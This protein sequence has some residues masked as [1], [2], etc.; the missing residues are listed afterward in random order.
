MGQHTSPCHITE[1]A[2]EKPLH[3]ITWDLII[4]LAEHR[5]LRV[6]FKLLFYVGWSMVFERRGGTF[7]KCVCA[8]VRVY[9]R[10]HICTNI[11]VYCTNV[12]PEVKLYR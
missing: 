2:T 11:Y 5:A 3:E 10:I 9:I 12:S 7:E 4:S 1:R 8:C 6:L